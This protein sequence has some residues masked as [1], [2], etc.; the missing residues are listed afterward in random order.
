[1]GVKG[2]KSLV[3]LNKEDILTHQE[4]HDTKVIIDGNNLGY[5]LYSTFN[6]DLRHNGNYD[7]FKS[8]LKKY[9]DVLRKCN[10]E[11]Y[12]VFTGC[13]NTEERKFETILKRT[14][15]GIQQCLCI[16]DGQATDQETTI[17]LL[18]GE[19][20]RNTLS[21][22]DIK[23]MKCCFDASPQIAALANKWDCPVIAN[24]SDFFIF[25]VKKGVITFDNLRI[26]DAHTT[27]NENAGESFVPVDVYHVDNFMKHFMKIDKA[28]LPVFAS[29]RGNEIVD[30]VQLKEFHHVYMYSK[31]LN[32]NLTLK[33]Q[34][35]KPHQERMIK[36]LLWMDTIPAKSPSAIVEKALS[37][38]RDRNRRDDVRQKVEKSVQSYLLDDVVD[39]S[40]AFE[41]DWNPYD[42]ASDF[43]HLQDL[44]IPQWFAKRFSQDRIDNSVLDA[45][46][47]QKVFL[48]CQVEDFTQPSS[49]ACARKIRQ[50]TY[51][52]L[53][54]GEDDKT[55]IRSVC[56]FDR[57]QRR[58]EGNQI[59]MKMK[60]NGKAIPS[61]DQ[62]TELEVA[63]EFLYHAL[64]LDP[65]VIQKSDEE[66]ALMAM[67][68]WRNT[69]KMDISNLHIYALLLC[70]IKLALDR[71]HKA[72]P[73]T[74]S[75]DVLGFLFSKS[76]ELVRKKLKQYHKKAALYVKARPLD[77][78]IIH[79][80]AEYQSIFSALLNL[81]EVL[82]CPVK[83][84]CPSLVYNGVFV[85]NVFCELSTHSDAK[86]YICEILDE[87][88]MGFSDMFAKLLAEVTK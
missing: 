32:N 9:F 43:K 18:A 77:I 2:L 66:L 59:A 15:E 82:R 88:V 23:Y 7:K 67:A 65:S 78:S 47:T 58:V 83:P 62:I 71:E 51:S 28:I 81:N 53:C 41:N 79:A 76:V 12:V 49:H 50:I 70:M 85:Y 1:M 75:S 13:S 45:L 8:C 26:A 29:L 74:K 55:R 30:I 64:E 24:D 21:E 44:K 35:D 73:R 86:F 3:D 33:Y 57:I 61:L 87:A 20:L 36:L 5:D 48:K 39:L 38:I 34:K 54:K 69:S 6:L 84:I 4:L 25:D 42:D 46:Y 31:V 52:I 68:F 60:V 56:E 63:G 10:I 80:F 37:Y 14:N 11:P 27:S 17:P 72:V 40:N 19:V 16:V 22:L